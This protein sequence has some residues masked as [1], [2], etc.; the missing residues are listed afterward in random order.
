RSSLDVG[1]A[2]AIHEGRAWVAFLSG[3]A[4]GWRTGN[5]AARGPGIRFVRSLR[6]TSSL[7]RSCPF[8]RRTN[9]CPT[10]SR[11]KHGGARGARAR[12]ARRRGPDR[13]RDC[14]REERLAEWRQYARTASAASFGP[15]GGSARTAQGPHPH[16]GATSD[17]A[18]R[19]PTFRLR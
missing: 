16:R 4:V 15:R 12:R 1:L 7:L 6:I 9:A 13:G 3:I 19:L 5:E 14:P 8:R 10:R 18:A 11:G 17:G 2:D